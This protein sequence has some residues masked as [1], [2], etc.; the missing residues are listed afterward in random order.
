MLF[1]VF[2]V[3]IDLGVKSFFIVLVD[4]FRG[5]GYQAHPILGT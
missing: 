3:F 4:R 1:F 5:L 2:I